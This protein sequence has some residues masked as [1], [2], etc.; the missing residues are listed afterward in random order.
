VFLQDTT[1]NEGKIGLLKY[2]EIDEITFTNIRVKGSKA[3]Q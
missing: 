3:A 2:W 1:D